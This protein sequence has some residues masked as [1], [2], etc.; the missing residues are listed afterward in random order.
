M[1]LPHV[2]T[3]AAVSMTHSCYNYFYFWALL[4]VQEAM[5]YK[6]YFLE[7]DWFSFLGFH[8]PD[9]TWATKNEDVA[10]AL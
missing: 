1:A 8:R 2:D 4:N 9:A 10:E 6:W 5:N 7:I 3:H